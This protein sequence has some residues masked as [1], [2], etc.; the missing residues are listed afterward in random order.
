MGRLILSANM[1]IDPLEGWFQPD[2]A[3]AAA[4]VRKGC[5]ETVLKMEDGPELSSWPD[6][7]CGAA[8][9]RTRVLRHFLEA[10][11]CA[12]RYVSTRIS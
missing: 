12:V 6:F 10:S 9:N 5:A 7:F 8:G 4:T 2:L 1:V 3:A 11:P